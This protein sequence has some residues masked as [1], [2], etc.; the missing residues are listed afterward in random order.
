MLNIINIKNI[1]I[2]NNILYNVFYNINLEIWL[3]IN[4]FNILALIY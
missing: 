2:N 1:D 3:L 4:I